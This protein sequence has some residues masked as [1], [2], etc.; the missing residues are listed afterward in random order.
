MT[1][2]PILPVLILSSA[3]WAAAHVGKGQSSHQRTG[4]GNSPRCTKNRDK[5]FNRR[6]VLEQFAAILNASVPEFERENGFKFY[7]KDERAGAFGV[8][9]L[10]DPSNVDSR[11]SD[12]C[13][14]FLDGH[15]YHVFPSLN[16]Y[17]FSHIIILEGGNLKVFRSVNCPGRGTDSRM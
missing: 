13:I 2:H 1:R 5:L 9:D 8:H 4:E 15:I 3:L 14:E 7:V 16:T 11:H 6:D 17:S 10:T 12:G